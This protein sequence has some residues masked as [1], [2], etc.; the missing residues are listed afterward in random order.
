VDWVYFAHDRDQEWGS[1][2]MV[3]RASVRTHPSDSTS[4]DIMLFH[5]VSYNL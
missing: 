1:V 3:M 5:E 4:S 2:D